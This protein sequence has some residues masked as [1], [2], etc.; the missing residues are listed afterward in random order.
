MNSTAFKRILSDNKDKVFSYAFY[1][2]HNREDAED[3]TQEVFVR[4]WKNIAAVDKNRVTAWMMRVTHNCCIDLLRQ[5]KASIDLQKKTVNVDFN[6]LP[7]IHDTENPE[8]RMEITDTQETLLRAMNT[9]PEK[10]KSMMIMHYYQGLKFET[11]G[12]IMNTNVNSVKV[13]VHRGRKTLRTVLENHFPE[14]IGNPK[15]EFAL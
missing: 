3:I 13:A 15:H 6:T 9:L 11:I 1:I 12:E 8:K 5:K 4:L 2:L 14:K 10:T 7:S